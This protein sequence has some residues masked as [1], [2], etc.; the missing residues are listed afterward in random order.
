MTDENFL[1]CRMNKPQVA[2]NFFSELMVVLVIYKMDI[3][4]SSAFTSLTD[5]LRFVNQ[6]TS[7][8]IYDN[9]PYP[10]KHSNTVN[11]NWVVSY[12]NDPSNPGVSKA[13]NEGFKHAKE[14]AKKWML[15]SDQDTRFPATFFES[16]GT[17]MTNHPADELFAPIIKGDSKLIS[18]FRFKF[19]KG[20][21]LQ[22]IE[23]QCYSLDELKFINSGL[24]ISTT[25]FEKCNGYDERF[26][27]DFSDLA[28]IQRL[29][30]YND[31]FIVIKATCSHNL[32]SDERTF[33]K[34]V[35]RFA[36]FV[37]ASRMY[38]RIYNQRLIFFVSRSL[39]AIKLSFR[40]RSLG[41]IKCLFNL[42]NS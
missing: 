33:S 18:P 3:G 13:Y 14:K 23:V 42:S 41:F 32:S 5:A 15:L 27:L 26:P 38:G 29:K 10:H 17:S 11:E 9:S 12:R 22:S 40:F 2:D 28:F 19:G 21:V 16:V 7:V 8:L 34:S 30:K 1:P 24:L 4:E 20:F 37:N 35:N 39:R 36:H 31:K 25:L 6:K